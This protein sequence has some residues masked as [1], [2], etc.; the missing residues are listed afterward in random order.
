MSTTRPDPK[1][2][3][4]PCAEP[5]CAQRVAWIKFACAADWARLPKHLRDDVNAAWLR[6]MGAASKRDHLE[7]GRAI[8]AHLDAC[9]R[10]VR[11]Y[12]A[13]P[14]ITATIGDPS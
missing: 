6:R 1:P 14:P 11:W 3:T 5:T 12:R 10:A 4:R 7:S 9:T 2:L 8:R 13:N